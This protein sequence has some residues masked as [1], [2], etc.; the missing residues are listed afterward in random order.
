MFTKEQLGSL[1]ARATEMRVL[2]FNFYR[3]TTCLYYVAIEINISLERGNL[4]SAALF[5]RSR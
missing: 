2:L 4:V 5:G 3:A 1:G